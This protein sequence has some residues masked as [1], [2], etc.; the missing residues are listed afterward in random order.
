MRGA[1]RR[2]GQIQP[3]RPLS[4][5]RGDTEVT[6]RTGIPAEPFRA[7]CPPCQVMQLTNSGLV[8]SPS[9]LNHFVECEHLTALDLLA[10]EGNG[11]AKEKDPQA[12][13]LRAKGFEH[14]QAWLQHLREEGREIVEI[15]VNGNADWHRDA[16]R[17]AA[18]MRN[19]AEVI[20]QA[21]FVDNDWRGVADFLI[22][23]DR[24]S[25]L[26]YVRFGFLPRAQRSFSGL[27]HS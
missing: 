2:W 17:T 27:A 3:P 7:A 15:A 11:V 20:Y 26:A 23:V 6:L 22:R 4:E 21:V 13:I 5:S 19:G 9:D 24:A 18:A 8:C 10:T 16:E 1:R 25:R 12:E 14:E